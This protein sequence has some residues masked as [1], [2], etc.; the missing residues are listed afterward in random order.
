MNPI[1][2]C[3]TL[4]P[5]TR[6]SRFLVTEWTSTLPSAALWRRRISRRSL[7]SFLLLSTGTDWQ[8]PERQGEGDVSV[9][10]CLS[11]YFLVGLF[12]KA[13]LFSPIDSKAHWVP[14]FL[15]RLTSNPE[16]KRATVALVYYGWRFEAELKPFFILIA[17]VNK[18]IHGFCHTT[19]SV[20]FEYWN[21]ER[22]WRRSFQLF[23]S[24]PVE[25]PSRGLKRS[26]QCSYF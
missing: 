3:E 23:G 13:H 9:R 12:T 22:L 20:C 16:R 21:H 19:Q 14:S 17:I 11:H 25:Q 2:G 1:E 6:G 18:N 10:F 26:W 24:K 8:I 5:Q 7:P 4:R 15:S